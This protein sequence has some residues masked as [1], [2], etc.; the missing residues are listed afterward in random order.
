MCT[1]L[2][3]VNIT[4]N[5]LGRLFIA[6]VQSKRSLSSLFSEICGSTR[7]FVLNLQGRYDVWTPPPQKNVEQD[8]NF[9]SKRDIRR[10]LVLPRENSLGGHLRRVQQNS[11]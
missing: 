9:D 6:S 11:Y 7:N 10:T 8:R 5:Q 3:R 4:I 1:M 2:Q